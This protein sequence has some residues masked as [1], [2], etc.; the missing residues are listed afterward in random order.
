M[1]WFPPGFSTPMPHKRDHTQ[2]QRE[3]LHAAANPTVGWPWPSPPPGFPFPRPT[4]DTY[5]QARE[6]D[7][8]RCVIPEQ[9]S[10]HTTETSVSHTTSLEE[11]SARHTEG[12][13]RADP[14]STIASPTG[15]DYTSGDEG[16]IP[17]QEYR[18]WT[19]TDIS[20]VSGGRTTRFGIRFPEA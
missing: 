9:A 11:S 1:G 6:R 2:T 13:L 16:L 4:V 3:G 7:A 14:H 19:N 12:T 8:P 15:M 10:R 17:S 20:R 5:Q 18:D